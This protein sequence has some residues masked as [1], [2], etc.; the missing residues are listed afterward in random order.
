MSGRAVKKEPDEV[1]EGQ[2]GDS[3]LKGRE[4]LYQKE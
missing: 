3:D 4:H 1:Y 2:E